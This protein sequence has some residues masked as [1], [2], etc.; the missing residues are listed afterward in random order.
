MILFT[1]RSLPFTR[2]ARLQCIHHQLSLEQLEHRKE[3]PEDGWW[4]GAVVHAWHASVWE[5]E[6]E[7]WSWLRGHPGLHSEL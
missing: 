2:G 3:Q 7:D 1:S 4:V 5:T 6:Q